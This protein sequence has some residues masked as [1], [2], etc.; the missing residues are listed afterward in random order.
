[1]SWP[2]TRGARPV[3]QAQVSINKL[4]KKYVTFMFDLFF[5]HKTY[6]SIMYVL[7]TYGAQHPNDVCAMY[8]LCI[9]PQVYVDV[10][11]NLC[12]YAQFM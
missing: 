6:I 9:V 2:W 7:C 8:Y 12:Y 10:M 3:P 5:K 11:D 4:C 1:V